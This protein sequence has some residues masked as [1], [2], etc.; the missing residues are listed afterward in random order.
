M[1]GPVCEEE[2]CRVEWPLESIICVL[3]PQHN[4]V[5][6]SEG[7]VPQNIHASKTSSASATY[8]ARLLHLPPYCLKLV[9]PI[10]LFFF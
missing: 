8:Y 3:K 5:S 10:L 9:D 4:N 2:G 7:D 1:N 6:L